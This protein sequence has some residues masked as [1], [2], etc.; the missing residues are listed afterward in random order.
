MG[1]GNSGSRVGTALAL[2][3]AVALCAAVIVGEASAAKLVGKD[4][5]VYACYKAKGK[6]KGA[7][8]LVAKN[9]TAA[10]VKRRSPG[11]SPARP[12]KTGR[13]AK[14]APV[15]KAGPAAKKARPRRAWKNRSSR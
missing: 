5:K 15:E 2:L 4:G 8:R 12:G 13:A 3:A 1:V 6:R 14:T 7:V 11:A 9:A 10:R